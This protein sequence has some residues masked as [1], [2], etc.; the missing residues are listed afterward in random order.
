MDNRSTKFTFSDKPMSSGK[1]N[2]VIYTRCSHN[3]KRSGIFFDKRRLIIGE[4]LTLSFANECRH[5]DGST[6]EIANA[7]NSDIGGNAEFGDL[8]NVIKDGLSEL[9]KKCNANV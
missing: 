9:V 2:I 4:P 6:G 8:M 7:E 5:C 3:D 1:S